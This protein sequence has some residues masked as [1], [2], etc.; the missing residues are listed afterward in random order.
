MP[1][2]PATSTGLEAENAALRA[3]VDALE[4]EVAELRASTAATVA[5]AQETLYWF[6]RWGVDF[7]GLFA[8][9]QMELLRKG[10]RAVRSVYR[11]ALKAKRRVLP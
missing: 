8:R 7:N 9:P 11:A 10:V 6:E 3:R 1:G 5:R 4:T 2:E